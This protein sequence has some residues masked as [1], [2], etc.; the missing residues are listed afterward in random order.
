MCCC[1]ATVAV[2]QQLRR[3]Y[4]GTNLIF[5]LLRTNNFFM[6]ALKMKL[7]LFITRIIL[8]SC[9]VKAWSLLGVRQSA[10]AS[11]A[12]DPSD[13]G[14]DVSYPIQHYINGEKYPYFRK[15]YDDRIQG[16][17]KLYSKSECEQTENV[18]LKM[19]LGII[20]SF[21]YINHFSF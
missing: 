13:Y 17:F 4:K 12:S 19:N 15:V 18:R 20:C 14:V 1:C 7:I 3:I 10:L 5:S 9:S 16:C 6:V 11:A 8:L 21:F 2:A